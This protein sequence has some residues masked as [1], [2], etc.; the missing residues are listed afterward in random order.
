MRCE[1][2]AGKEKQGM[3]CRAISKD[4]TLNKQAY[5]SLAK[6]VRIEKKLTAVGRC[7]SYAAL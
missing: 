4:R 5:F 7:K 3:G 2:L 1:D 6:L